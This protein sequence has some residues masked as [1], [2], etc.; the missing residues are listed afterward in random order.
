MVLVLDKM[1]KADAK[2]SEL[3]ETEQVAVG[4]YFRAVVE[5]F[6]SEHALY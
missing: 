4:Y 1:F 5:R 6:A 3:D 2:F